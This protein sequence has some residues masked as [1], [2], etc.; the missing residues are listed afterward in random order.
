MIMNN[1]QTTITMTANKTQKTVTMTATTAHTQEMMV[2]ITSQAH[3]H[4]HQS[5]QLLEDCCAH[6]AQD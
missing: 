4:G 3:E 2:T 1:T 6:C 5:Q